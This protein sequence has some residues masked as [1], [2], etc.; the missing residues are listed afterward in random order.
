MS[1]PPTKYGGPIFRPQ[2]SPDLVT[3]NFT[4]MRDCPL[5]DSVLAVYLIYNASKISTCVSK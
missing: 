3:S 4:E 1:G 2:I 5:H